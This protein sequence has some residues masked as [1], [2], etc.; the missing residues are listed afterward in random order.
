MKLSP[1]APRSAP[2]S[3][4]EG[5]GEVE[6]G[7]SHG[8][9]AGGVMDTLL[10]ENPCDYPQH[11]SNDTLAKIQGFHR[12]VSAFFSWVSAISLRDGVYFARKF[13]GISR[14]TAHTYLRTCVIESVLYA[15]MTIAVR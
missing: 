6:Y 2:P 14:R 13:V 11:I 10:H 3:L 4:R 15:I 7:R 8:R 12:K 1:I 5:Q 9:L